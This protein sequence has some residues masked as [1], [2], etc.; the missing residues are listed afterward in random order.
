MRPFGGE[1][2]EKKLGVLEKYLEAYLTIMHR[3]TTA[4]CSF[5]TTYLD[6]FAGTGRRYAKQD[7]ALNIGQIPLENLRP[8]LDEQ[9]AQEFVEY[10]G[11]V[12][13]AL[14]KGKYGGFNNYIFIETDEIAIEKLQSLKQEFPEKNI[15]IINQDANSYIPQWCQSLGEYERAVVFLDPFGLQV[16]WETIKAIAHTKKID[17]WLLTPLGAILRMLPRHSLPSQ[18]FVDT[19][20]R[21]F[22]TEKWQDAFY[23]STGQPKLFEEESDD[24]QRIIGVQQ[25]TGYF[26]KRLKQ[27]FPPDHVLEEP[28]VLRNSRNSPIYMLC[29]A[30]SNPKGGKA[31]L[32]IARDII[33]K[34]LRL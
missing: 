14:Q 3:N 6:G 27:V 33:A 21:F 28:M 15:E 2:T 32:K 31:A 12:L 13:R 22:G 18:A 17:L 20:T 30:A 7:S 5:T 26:V 1:W 10:E 24:M 25:I 16:C 8:E 34:E 23:A 19:L 9:I 29:F 4:R 11:S